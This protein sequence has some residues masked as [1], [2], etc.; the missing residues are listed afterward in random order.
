METLF[1][2]VMDVEVCG[3]DSVI[4]PEHEELFM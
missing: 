3:A 2:P 1:I 4:Y